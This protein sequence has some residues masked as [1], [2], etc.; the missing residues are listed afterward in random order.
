MSELE[1]NYTGFRPRDDRT[2]Q[3]MAKHGRAS[4]YYPRVWYTRTYNGNKF[5]L[6]TTHAWQSKPRG[7]WNHGVVRCVLDPFVSRDSKTGR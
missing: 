3:N 1:P 6:S 2:T 4:P 5:F 7:P